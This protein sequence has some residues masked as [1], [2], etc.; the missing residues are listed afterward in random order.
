MEVPRTLCALRSIGKMGLP[1]VYARLLPVPQIAGAVP[2]HLSGRGRFIVGMAL[3][4]SPM[5]EQFHQHARLAR[6]RE[7]PPCS[8]TRWS[9]DSKADAAFRRELQRRRLQDRINEY[10]PEFKLYIAASNHSETNHAS[11]ARD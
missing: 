9:D 2:L 3:A 10:L 11:D 1:Q 8:A 5:F 4:Q 7:T 6:W